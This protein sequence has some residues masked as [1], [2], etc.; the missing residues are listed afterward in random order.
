MATVPELLQLFRAALRERLGDDGWTELDDPAF[1]VELAHPV[2]EEFVAV[3]EIDRMTISPDRAPV[4]I[5]DVNAAVS[6]LPL[7]RLWPLLGE[8]WLEPRVVHPLREPGDDE[9]DLEAWSIA[10]GG[11]A[12]A[13]ADRVAALVRDHVL[14]FASEHAAVETMLAWFDETDGPGH[15]R[16]LALL[17]AAGR[18]DEARERLDAFDPAQGFPH[19]FDDGDGARRFVRQ[20]RRW[21][22]S[23]GDPRLRTEAPPPPRYDRSVE[24]FGT[25]WSRAWEEN[26]AIQAVQRVAGGR[27]RDELRALLEAELARRNLTETPVWI[28]K[29]VDT[30]SLSRAE[31]WQRAGDALGRVG[32]GLARVVRD[33]RLPD[34]S[35]PELLAAP[36]RAT[37]AVPRHRSRVRAV[38]R[39]DPDAHAWL[40]E[41]YDALP[42][43]LDDPVD[44]DAWL[45]T[46]AAAGTLAVHVGPSRVGT[47]DEQ[48]AAS[49]APVM[50]AAAERDELPYTAAGIRRL[51]NG[52]Y[53]LEVQ[54]PDPD[55]GDDT[56]PSGS[57]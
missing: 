48:A 20:L 33:G 17:A 12:E 30:L 14:G 9:D 49:F 37:Y 51:A 29:T 53:L 44:F 41:V 40:D 16:G 26:Q 34:L 56:R 3:A 47:L 50:R 43:V 52:G 31:Q 1:A 36:E 28:E 46:D 22:D 21:I 54:L 55:G 24:S 35:V 23:G 4:L 25:M 5:T 18:L 38:V 27:S 7:R 57:S 11:D 39:L 45:D 32:A 8:P 42:K 6:Y 2:D 10:S 13:V 15:Y 19:R